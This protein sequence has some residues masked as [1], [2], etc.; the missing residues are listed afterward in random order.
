M[1]S[2]DPES[3]KRLDQ[4]VDAAFGFAVT[5]LIITGVQPANLA[6]LKTALPNIPASAAAFVLTVLFWQAHKVF[7]RLTPV[8]DTWTLIF[9]LAIVFT[10]LVYVFPLRLLTQSLFYW[11]SFGRLPGEGL[12]NSYGDLAAL[13]QLYG[14][15]FA[16][17]SGLYAALFARAM[18]L[19]E[20]P[21]G[22]EDARSWRDS[23]IICAASGVASAL[24]AFAPL[25]YI[26]W[27]PP[28]TYPLIPLAIWLREAL[29]ARPRKPKPAKAEA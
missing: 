25:D 29:L 22:R 17:L 18:K 14:L 5:L 9:S 23:W 1:S 8:R 12:I 20:D 11:V 15:G 16:V 21:A 19:A 7:G 13:Y 26:S 27:L 2:S 10:V 28:M 24:I 6:E 3:R 4:F